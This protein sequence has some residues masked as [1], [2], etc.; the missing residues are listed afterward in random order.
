MKKL[1]RLIVTSATYKQSSVATPE[2]LEKDPQNRLLA[3]GPRIR[4]TGELIRDHMLAASG[5]LSSKMYGRGVYP[6]QPKTVLSHAF[7]NQ[8]WNVSTGE[9]RYRRSLYTFIKRT[10]PFAGYITFDGT[11]GENCLAKRDRSNTP[12]QALTL[13]NDEMFIELAQAAGELVH[14]KKEDP[15]ESLFR[16]FLTRM[17]KAEERKALQGYFDQQVERLQAGELKAGDIAGNPK[18]DP[19]WAGKVLLARAIMN[20]DETITKP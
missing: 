8:A 17:P 11:S 20:L 9:D 13:L 19:Q 4:L 14:Q 18:A 7:G 1:H 16:R 12:L 10:A 15:V 5:K 2:L 6:P 3:R